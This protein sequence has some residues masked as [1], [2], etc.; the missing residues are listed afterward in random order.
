MDVQRL[1]GLSSAAPPA[2][3]FSAPAA[4]PD[5]AAPVDRVD[6]SLRG[7]L[8]SVKQRSRRLLA[9]GARMVRGVAAKRAAI[10]ARLTRGQKVLRAALTTGTLAG[11]AIAAPLAAP[12][13]LLAGGLIGAAAGGALTGVLM[14][15]GWPGHVP[16]KT[17]ARAATT[18]EIRHDAVP[19]S[20]LLDADFQ[21]RITEKTGVG[22]TEG[23]RIQLLE[24]GFESFDQRYHLIETAQKSIRLQS[25]IFHDDET[26]WNTARLLAKRAQ[27]GVDVRVILDGLGT[28]DTGTAILD[29]MR[30]AG[31]KVVE[32]ATPLS[33]PLS[34]N[35]RWHQKILAVDDARAI[36]GG[37]NVGSEYAYAGTGQVDL[38]KG[39]TSPSATWMWDTDVLVEGPAVS[40]VIESFEEN[41]ELDTGVLVSSPP[42]I[43]PEPD[44]A[45]ARFI[46]HLPKERAQ[47]ILGE[48]YVDM[49]DNASETAYIS[50][51]YFVPDDKTVDAMIRAAKRG[52]DV[53]VVT[54]SPESTD[55]PM[56]MVQ[57]AG[58]SRY[59]RL[60][61]GGVRVYELQSHGKVL[62]CLHKKAAV[63][64]GIVSAVGSYNLDPRSEHLNSEDLMEVHGEAF[65]LQMTEAFAL[66]LAQAKLVTVDSLKSGTVLDRVE[67]W[68]YGDVLRSQL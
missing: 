15:P 5:D 28:A 12:L 26:G 48:W 50:N 55:A 21:R 57:Q 66:D 38:S 60:I 45:P 44:G 51:A 40:D 37:M 67:Q 33:S 10:P 63:F 4:T 56:P 27:E 19:G 46:R 41:W 11:L 9:S 8:A 22:L 24:N 34:I 43:P 36:V 25:Y 49:L 68:F 31:V 2:A 6:H 47:S 64:D 20:P 58:R 52:V 39:A 54:N 42:A 14:A 18:P 23:N 61:E 13:A 30:E 29:L 53:R 65:G 1:T 35:H 32:H 59:E 7:R 16:G 3:R 17:G 62:R